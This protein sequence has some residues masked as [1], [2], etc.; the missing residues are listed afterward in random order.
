MNKPKQKSAKQ[1]SLAWHKK[2]LWKWFSKYIRK[3]DGG[4]CITCPRANLTGSNYHAG[5]FF[6]ASVCG[7]ALY[8][9]PRNVYG[10]CAYCN[11]FL[12]GNQ[13]EYGVRLGQQEVEELK[14]IKERT[15]GVVWD[16]R[17]YQV[18]IEKY[19]ELSTGTS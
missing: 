18:L 14:A 6:K 13:Y 16:R 3:R 7:L 17:M 19:K 10:Q 8:F 4:K 12:D 2:E 9:S 15:K 1:K 11:L 5:H